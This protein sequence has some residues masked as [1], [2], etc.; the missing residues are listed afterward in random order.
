MMMNYVYLS[1]YAKIFVSMSGLH[2]DEFDDLVSAARALHHAAAMERLSRPNRPRAD[3]GG[4]HPE[5][6]VRDQILLTGLWLRLYPTQDVL[7]YF[8]GVSQTTVSHSLSQVLPILERDGL[9]RMRRPQPGRTGRRPWDE[10]LKDRPVTG[11]S[12]TVLSKKYSVRQTPPNATTGT[13]AR[14]KALP[15]SARWRWMKQWVKSSIFPTAGLAPRL[16]AS[17]WSSPSYSTSCPTA[18]VAGATVA[19]RA[20]LNCI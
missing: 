5:L 18:W 2:V 19:I 7:G 13:A 9:E 15:S 4:D 10:L 3:G 17:S 1:G 16:I 20:S 11:S 8:L 12:S 6:A 14:R